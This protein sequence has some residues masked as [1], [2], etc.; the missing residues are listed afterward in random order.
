MF[1]SRVNGVPLDGAQEAAIVFPAE[2]HQALNLIG[3]MGQSVE[4]AMGE[5]G[6][7][8]TTISARGTFRYPAG[9]DQNNFPIRIGFLGLEC[10]PETRKAS[11]D[12]D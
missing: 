11:P 10:S 3:K 2:G 9:L 8:K 5:R 4:E 12:D 1:D 7:G 6:I